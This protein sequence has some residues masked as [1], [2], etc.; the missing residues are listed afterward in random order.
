M[1]EISFFSKFSINSPNKYILYLAG[2][3]FLLSL[4]FPLEGINPSDLR[5][6]ALIFIFIGILN[7]VFVSIQGRRYDILEAEAEERD[8]I[9]SS[10]KEEIIIWTIFEYALFIISYIIGLFIVFS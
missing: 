10:T 3:S 5:R 7:W 8:H 2:L 1:N 4:V 6:G 9:S